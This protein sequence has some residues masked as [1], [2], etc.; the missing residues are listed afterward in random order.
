[1]AK[2]I[3]VV[4]HGHMPYVL[5]HGTWPHGE[6]WLYEAA[7]EVYLPLLSMLE[8]TDMALTLGMTPVLLTQLKSKA[9]IDGMYRYLKENLKLVVLDKRD[10]D[11]KDGAIYWEGLIQDRLKQF[12][13]YNGDIV[14]ALVRCVE[15]G[16]LELLSSFATHGYA[17]LLSKDESI[18]E[19]INV[20]LA[21]SESILGFRPKGIWL[22]ECAFAP[23]R[24]CFG[25]VRRGVDRI[26][27]DAGVE[28]FYVEDQAF[29]HAR[30]EGL[31]L[32]NEFYKTDWD[33]VHHS[34]QWAWRSL[35]EPHWISTVGEASKIAAFA[36]EPSLCA[37]IWSAEQGY[38]GDPQYLEF[39]KKSSTSG[40]RYW[41]ITDRELTMD[42]KK[43]YSPQLAKEKARLH[44]FHFARRCAELLEHYEKSGRVGTLTCCFDAELFGHWWH[45]GVFF[46]EAFEKEVSRIDG[47][48]LQ[49]GSQILSSNPPDKVI[50]IP[51]CSWGAQADHRTWNND[52]TGW[53]WDSL[54][55]AEQQYH[56]LC[57]EISL[58]SEYRQEELKKLMRQL[59]WNF[60][61]LQSSDWAFVISTKGAVDY[62]FR[63]FS[64]HLERFH[65]LYALIEKRKNRQSWSEKDHIVYQEIV[66]HEECPS[67]LFSKEHNE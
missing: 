29:V 63:R 10:L 46:L 22:P 56:T 6:H 1:M 62:G 58:L 33:A 13:S 35:L 39:H 3:Q 31:L 49:T 55:G 21:M 23:Q 30:S 14:S 19:Q 15:K 17:P 9:F 25:T 8:R 11:L 66:L 64:I 52:T 28:F 7:F 61:L 26:L 53:M 51:E 4:L 24:D 36:R 34:P 38:P 32:E 41:R 57:S 47:V 16:K 5:H 43:L 40:F 37:Q 18:E 48:E 44:A 12:A 67:S 2:K 42:A 59:Q 45:E 50:W 65:R 20:G 27:E 60:L 54:H